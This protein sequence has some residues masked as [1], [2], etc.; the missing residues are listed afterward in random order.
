MNIIKRYYLFSPS[1][2]L[3]LFST[4][5][6]SPLSFSEEN[7]LLDKVVITSTKEQRS[8]S[9]LAESV[10]VLTRQEILNV[11]PSHPSEILNRSAG[12][13]INNLGGEG[14]MTAIR[15]P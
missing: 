2:L 5:A 6:L 13:Y 7:T 4:I 12:V 11:S 15:Q 1:I 8:K 14:H 10:S 3:L 9:E